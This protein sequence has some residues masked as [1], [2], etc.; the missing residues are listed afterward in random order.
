MERCAGAVA[1]TMITTNRKKQ[2]KLS[3]AGIVFVACR[4]PF[5]R[6]PG[7]ARG[8]HTGFHVTL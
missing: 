7:G 4:F 6:A 5:T 3:S 8:G 1:M 2:H